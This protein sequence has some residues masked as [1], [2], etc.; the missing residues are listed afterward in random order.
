MAEGSAEI[1]RSEL[2]E[3]VWAIP[4]RKLAQQYGLSDVGLAKICKKHQIPRPSRGYWAKREVLRRPMQ[5]P[6]PHKN[7]DD[8]IR[9][10]PNPFHESNPRKKEM[11]LEEFGLK[12]LEEPIFVAEDL[13]KPHPLVK[14]SSEMLKTFQPDT[15]GIIFSKQENCLDIQVSKKSLRRAL[16]IMDALIKALEERDC[17]VLLSGKSTDVRILDTVLGISLSEQLVRE[18]KEPEDPDFDGHYRF[19]H[20]RFEERSSPSG[21]LCL[22]IKSGIYLRRPLQQ[23]WRDGKTQRL[24]TCLNAFV[25]G[26]ARIAIHKKECLK[27]REQEE[28]ERLERERKWAEERRKAEEEK[29]KFEAL[30]RNVESWQKS[31]RIREYIAVV[32]EMA[33][34]GKYTFNFEGGVESWLKWAKAK[35]DRLDPL[36]PAPRPPKDSKEN[37]NSET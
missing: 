23:S 11:A 26:L 31:R 2:Y 32:E 29:Q 10:N 34:T 14:L 20:S 30:V 19:S 27:I 3:R 18:K 1:R 15:R 24:E 17:K 12:N 16:L 37:P 9:I 25:K 8:I 4:M 22:A 5:T 21:N 7:T 35:A 6:L 36:F 33:S 13:R 28:Q